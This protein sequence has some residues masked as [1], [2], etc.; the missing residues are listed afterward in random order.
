M[1]VTKQKYLLDVVLNS[2][3]VC[4]E[5]GSFRID[6]EVPDFYYAKVLVECICA[7][8][9]AGWDLVFTLTNVDI[10]RPGGRLQL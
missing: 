5:C 1:V 8:C 3:V 6:R 7:D 2:R 10:F 4:P 9:L